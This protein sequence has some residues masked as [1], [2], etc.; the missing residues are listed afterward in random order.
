MNRRATII[1]VARVAGSP[2]LTSPRA[3]MAE[4]FLD[5]H[6]VAVGWIIRLANCWRY[7]SAST[8]VAELHSSVSRQDLESQ[9]VQRYLGASFVSTAESHVLRAAV[10]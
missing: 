10:E 9:I 5:E 6:P 4:I 8:H 2:T 1:R 3:V 7:E